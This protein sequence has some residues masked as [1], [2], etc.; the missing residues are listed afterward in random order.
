MLSFKE[1]LKVLIKKLEFNPVNLGG[2]TIFTTTL[3]ITLGAIV[4]IIVISY[5]IGKVTSL[6]GPPNVVST[7]FEYQNDPYELDLT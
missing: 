7:N 4:M 6:Y 2:N 3:G 1:G 5:A